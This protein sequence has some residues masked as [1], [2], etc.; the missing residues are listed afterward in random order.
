MRHLGRLYLYA[1]GA[2]CRDEQRKTQLLAVM[3]SEMIMRC[4]KELF[5]GVM[6]HYSSEVTVKEEIVEH[7]NYLLG[8]SDES[9]SYFSLVIKLLLMYKFSLGPNRTDFDAIWERPQTKL[10]VYQALQSKLGISF[11]RYPSFP[12]MNTSNNLSHC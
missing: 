9:R 10:E 5:R 2:S 4:A 11:N 3:A 7:F 8:N 1:K 6:R 12:I